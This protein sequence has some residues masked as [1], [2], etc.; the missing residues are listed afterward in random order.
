MKSDVNSPEIVVCDDEADCSRRVAELL[1]NTI[2]AAPNV[3]LGLATGGTPVACYREL[4]RMH[5]EAQLDFSGVVTFNLDEYV[6]LAPSHPQSFRYF[7]QQHLFDH[8]NIP[9]HQTYVPNGLALD[10]DEHAGDYEELIES[11]GGIDL[12]LLGIGSNGHIAFNEPGSAKDS[13]TRLVQLTSDTIQANA[14]FF[15]SIDDVPRQAITMGI[16]TILEA[17][18]VLLMATGERKAE[19]VRR[20]IE[21]EPD[22]SVPASL[23]QTHGDVV[24]VLDSAAA[25]KLTR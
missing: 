22:E 15:D 19:I 23:L 14:R 25:S 3:T 18:R 20:A 4:V 12:Q 11:V 6:G 21:G 17:K 9:A 5:R 1:A 7:M 2:V 8:V 16:G 13:R 24:Y 10:V